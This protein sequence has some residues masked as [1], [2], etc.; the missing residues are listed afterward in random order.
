MY[1]ALENLQPVVTTGDNRLECF[2][3]DVDESEQHIVVPVGFVD[4]LAVNDLRDQAHC[5]HKF[6]GADLEAEIM[7]DQSVERLF[8]SHF[9]SPFHTHN[10]T[11]S[12][13][14][15]SIFCQV[16]VKGE[17]VGFNLWF[18]QVGDPSFY[19]GLQMIKFFLIFRLFFFFKALAVF[20]ERDENAH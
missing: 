7:A 20:A 14:L 10:V 8:L 17:K 3:S 11:G 19:Q 1:R 18:P 16:I 13:D 2:L 4:A 12:G 15:S 6:R 5:A 9:L